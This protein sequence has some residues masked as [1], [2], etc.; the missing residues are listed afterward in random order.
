MSNIAQ[1]NLSAKLKKI[2]EKR[3]TPS[4]IPLLPYPEIEEDKVVEVKA[5]EDK[6]VEE[7]KK[8][9]VV[10]TE[11]VKKV[12]DKAEESTGLRSYLYKKLVGWWWRK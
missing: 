11:E 1:D 9:E 10:A 2:R 8:T 7:A 6:K 3:K 5:V 4:V 12:E